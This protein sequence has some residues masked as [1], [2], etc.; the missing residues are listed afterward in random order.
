MIVAHLI[1]G[2]REEPILPALLKSLEPFTDVLLVNDNART[3]DGV[4]AE[5]LARSTFALEGRMHVDRSPFVTSPMRAI[6][7]SRCTARTRPR[8]GRPSSM[9]M[10]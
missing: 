5:V 7:C 4:N 9:P 6:A 2:E 3:D 8:H 10:T 1:V